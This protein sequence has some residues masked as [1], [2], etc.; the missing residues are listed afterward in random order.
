MFAVANGPG[1]FTGIRVGV[2]AAQA[3]AQAF[4]KP[5]VGISV[6]GAMIETAR[7]EDEVA[8][9]F[10]DARRGEL[11]AGVSRVL[12]G[13]RRTDNPTYELSQELLLKREAVAH[14]ISELSILGPVT[15]VIRDNDPWVDDL[16]A[17]VG[18]RLIQD[19]PGARDEGT[20]SRSPLGVEG[21][22]PPTDRLIRWHSIR[23]T[24]VAAIARIALQAHREGRLQRPEELDAGY[25]RRSDAEMHWYE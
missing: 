2:A 8:L 25:I 3:W 7:P 11:F 22:M 19:F 16:R 20:R 5:V 24:L 1:S 18:E 6:L 21:G 4:S 23:G 9:A 17:A 10:M 14:F 13:T 12:P 15:C